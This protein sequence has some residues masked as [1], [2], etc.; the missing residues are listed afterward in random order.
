MR[1]VPEEEVHRYMGALKEDFQ[2]MVSA[3][4][5][6]FSSLNEKLDEHGRILEMHTEMIGTLMEDVSVLKED[7]K[8]I[9]DVLEEKA[10]KKSVISL[11][12][13]VSRIE[14]LQNA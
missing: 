11:E 9:R 1:V 4:A 12:A 14:K 5:E 2:G 6:R 8:E 13:R 7:V 3:V 10:D